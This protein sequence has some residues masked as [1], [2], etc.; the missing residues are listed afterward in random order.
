[1]VYARVA[2]VLFNIFMWAVESRWQQR[3]SGVPGI[4][5]SFSHN[6]DTGNLYR[7]SHRTDPVTTATE[8]QFADDSA[9]FATSRAGAEVALTAFDNTA[10]EF[11]LAVSATK[12]KFL[13]A[14]ADVS[15]ADRVPLSLAGVD[16]VCITEFKY[17]G[18]VIHSGG[19]SSCDFDSRIANVSRACGALQK[20]IFGNKHLDV[21]IKRCVFNACV[22]SLL[23]YGSE[24]LTPLQRDLQRLSVFHHLC[25]RS[26][27]GVSRQ[28]CWD[29][30]ITNHQLR[31]RWGD[32]DT[33]R[34]K[35]ERRRLE[36]LGH[37]ARMEDHRLPKQVLFG[38]LPSRRPAHGP[39]RRWKDCIV[40]DLRSRGLEGEWRAECESRS[41]WR[42]AYSAPVDA[43]HPPPLPSPAT[44]TTH[45]LHAPVIAHATS[46]GL[47]VRSRLRS[48]KVHAS[49]ESV[50]VG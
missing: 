34:T 25:I 19:R 27:M 3:V 50:A 28:E 13:V 9:L 48:R 35:V 32:P 4:G 15:A 2:P 26:I 37:V 1:M 46:V 33:I 40:S 43:Q 16:I 11:G 22:L 41:T 31:V 30:H 29:D 7:K 21:H 8:A 38:T 17:L 44:P 6:S 18:S 49:V 36:W 12:T 47:S 14:G 45:S 42:S 5:F 23:L 39:R 20:S 10:S 24:C